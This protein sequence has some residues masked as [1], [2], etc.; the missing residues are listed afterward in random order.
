MSMTI[1]YLK[2][3]F[4]ATT[5]NEREFSISGDGDNGPAKA[6]REED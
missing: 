1:L 4:K 2:G 3:D 6:S 5:V